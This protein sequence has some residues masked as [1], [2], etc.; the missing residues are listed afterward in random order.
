MS[1]NE[2]ELETTFTRRSTLEIHLDI[3][4]IVKDGIR[5]PTRIMY[6]SNLSWKP[7]QKNLRSLVSNGFLREI[8]VSSERDRRSQRIYEITE[9]G[10]NVLR[11]LSSEVDVLDLIEVARSSSV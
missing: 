1:V 7:M 3:L 6:A 2:S 10:E 5:K 11:Y 4:K 9:K 8:K